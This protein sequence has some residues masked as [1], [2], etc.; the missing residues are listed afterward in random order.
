MEIV[1]FWQPNLLFSFSVELD[2]RISIIW[3]AVQKF[4]IHIIILIINYYY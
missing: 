1:I 3:F 4:N 2:F